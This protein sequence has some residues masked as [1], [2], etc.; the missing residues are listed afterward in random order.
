MAA[1]EGRLQAAG[2]RTQPS[3]LHDRGAVWTFAESAVRGGGP[4]HVPRCWAAVARQL[5]VEWNSDS[6]AAT[7]VETVAVV[8]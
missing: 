2:W 6:S 1:L 3:G 7:D 4:E 8:G 5:A